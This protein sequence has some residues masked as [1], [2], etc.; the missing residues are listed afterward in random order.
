MH[1][2]QQ[3]QT[4]NVFTGMYR[5]YMFPKRTE[6]IAS[7]LEITCVYYILLDNRDLQSCQVGQV[8]YVAITTPAEPTLCVLGHQAVPRLA[9]GLDSMWHISTRGFWSENNFLIS[10]L[11]QIARQCFQRSTWNVLP[12]VTTSW[13]FNTLRLNIISKLFDRT[14]SQ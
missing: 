4:Y 1:F 5:S 11:V 12:R 2:I 14:T 3:Q 7:Y 6:F 9:S 10:V 8:K 13:G